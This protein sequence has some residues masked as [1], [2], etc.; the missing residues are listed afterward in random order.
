MKKRK[1]AR[2]V[3]RQTLYRTLECKFKRT[4]MQH[5]LGP[6]WACVEINEF[7]QDLD[8]ELK[9]HNIGYLGKKLK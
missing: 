4:L 1:T 5:L 6:G 9:L 8:M 2:M 7:A 3:I